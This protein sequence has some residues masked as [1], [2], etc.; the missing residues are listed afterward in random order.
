MA[1]AYE[2]I[3]QGLKEAISLNEGKPIAAKVHRSEKLMLP[4]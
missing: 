2:T 3:V 4:Y 1:K